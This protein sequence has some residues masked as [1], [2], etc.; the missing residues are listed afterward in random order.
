MAKRPMSLH[1]A[2]LVLTC[3]TST[4]CGVQW[5]VKAM[6]MLPTYLEYKDPI[7]VVMVISWS[8]ASNPAQRVWLVL[9]SPGKGRFGNQ[10]ERVKKCLWKHRFSPRSDKDVLGQR[11]QTLL[12]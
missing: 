7:Y 12:L 11:Q 4:G 2:G 1:A 3:F 10:E 9:V 5:F 6:E 8:T